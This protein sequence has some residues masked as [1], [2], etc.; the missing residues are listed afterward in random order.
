[1]SYEG[2]IHCGLEIFEAPEIT[3]GVEDGTQIINELGYGLWDM[4]FW[5]TRN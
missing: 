4:K 3:V 5:S 2:Q 1:M